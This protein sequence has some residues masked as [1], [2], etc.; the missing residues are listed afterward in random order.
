[1]PYEDREPPRRFTDL[2]NRLE[3][4]RFTKRP[5][6]QRGDA[7]RLVDEAIRLLET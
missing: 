4:I 7:A 5:E 2:V 3:L 6:N 1:M